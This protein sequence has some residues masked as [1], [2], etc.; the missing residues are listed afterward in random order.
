MGGRITMQLGEGTI[1][2]K[3][4]TEKHKGLYQCFA[5]NEYGVAVSTKALVRE[6]CK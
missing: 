3:K 6:S 5:R 4:P 1:N 2:I